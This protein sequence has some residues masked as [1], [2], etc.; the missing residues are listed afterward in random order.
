MVWE[1]VKNPVRVVQ[2][3]QLCVPYGGDCVCVC[4]HMC[5]YIAD[6]K[7]DVALL[8]LGRQAVFAC[9]EEAPILAMLPVKTQ[10]TRRLVS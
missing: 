5:L 1:L 4:V 6:F 2:M 8:L 3:K 10:Q 7:G 9:A